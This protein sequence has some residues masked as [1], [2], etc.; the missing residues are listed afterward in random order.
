MKRRDF[1]TLI[2]GTAVTWPLAARGTS[3]T[4]QM[5]RGDDGRLRKN[6]AGEWPRQSCTAVLAANYFSTA[7]PASDTTSS[8][9]PVPPLTPIAPMTLPPTT[10]G[11]PPREAITSS[12][13]ARYEK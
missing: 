10:S 1:I 11:L 6:S 13:V 2:G 9:E 12:R 5:A 3:M 4:D 8:W 7:T